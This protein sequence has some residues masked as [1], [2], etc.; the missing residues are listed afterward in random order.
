MNRKLWENLASLYSVHAFN[1]LVPLFT[2]PYLAR[3]LGP[4]EWGALA[5]ADAYARFVS[6]AVE[7]GFGLS[8]TREI[9]R[10]RHDP[11]ARGRHLSGV[12]GAQLLLGVAA[13]LVTVILARFMPI[14]ASHRWLLPGAFF[15]AMSQG[16]AP[17]WYFQ[18]IERVRLMGALW[19][20]GRLAGALALLLFVHAPGDGPIALF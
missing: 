8:A 17:M 4:A 12:F 20:V 3:V 7:Y 2:L 13:L 10:I 15:W 18:G 19:I 6:L 14:F 11:P 9:A 16:A 5:F 1:Y